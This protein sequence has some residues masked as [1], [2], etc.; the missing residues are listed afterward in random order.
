MKKAIFVKIF[1]RESLMGYLKLLS[2]KQYPIYL[3][4]LKS[5]MA[6]VTY[7]FGLT[8][9]TRFDVKHSRINQNLPHIT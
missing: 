6:F 2:I 3:C 5:E 7:T 8:C 1:G 4:L 9:Y